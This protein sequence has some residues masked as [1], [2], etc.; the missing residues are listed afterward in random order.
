[1]SPS[2]PAYPFFDSSLLRYPSCGTVALERHDIGRLGSGGLGV[3]HAWQH[4]VQLMRYLFLLL[5]MSG[6]S[7]LAVA[8]SKSHPNPAPSLPVS[9][10][11]V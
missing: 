10:R 2:L 1:M 9:S 11:V 5:C 8:S 7:W 4:A 3:M 6:S